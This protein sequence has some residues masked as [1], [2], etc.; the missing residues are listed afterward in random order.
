PGDWVSLPGYAHHSRS[1]RKC[2]STILT[3]FI[4]ACPRPQIE[5]SL[6]TCISSCNSGSSP[7]GTVIRLNALLGAGAAWR[8]LAT[9]L[10]LEEAQ[11]VQR[12]RF[13]VVLVGEDDHRTRTG[14]AS[15]SF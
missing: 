4:A 13:H 6:M 9:A 3:G 1:S 14:K 10:V 11:Q 7:C 2:F 12:H 8:A 5:A 15:L